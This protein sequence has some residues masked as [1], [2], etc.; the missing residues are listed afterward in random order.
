MSYLCIIMKWSILILVLNLLLGQNVGIGTTSPIWNL[1][2][3]VPTNQ[4]VSTPGTAGIGIVSP[5]TEG[6]AQPALMGMRWLNHSLPY[7]WVLWL[8]D[9][10][11]GFGVLPNSLELW[12]YPSTNPCCRPR[13]RFVASRNIN[14]T[15]APLTV[16]ANHW[17]EAYDF[18]N[19]SDSAWK[20][21]IRPLE[22]GL[23]Q[24]L[25]LHPVTYRWKE[26][27]DRVHAGFLAQEVQQVMPEAVRRS[28]EGLLAI[29]PMAVAATMTRAI[30]ELSQRV[31]KLETWI[32]SQRSNP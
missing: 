25:D 15:R 31:E 8:A 21:Q 1:T 19:I 22:Y 32:S 6:D 9:P 28:P 2:V 12:E 7:S 24:I 5:M 16:T 17:L 13:L 10:D 11:G 29:D 30:Q 20:A 3:R 27:D 18:I 4:T 26:A 14:L 23:S